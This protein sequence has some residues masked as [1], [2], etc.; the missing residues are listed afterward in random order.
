MGEEKRIVIT[1]E[2]PNKPFDIELIGD[3]KAKEITRLQRLIVLAY[4]RR[5]RTI[6]QQEKVEKEE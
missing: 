5:N 4:R 3:W 6:R 1:Q 2:S